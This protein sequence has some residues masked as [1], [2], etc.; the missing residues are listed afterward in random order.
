MGKGPLHDV[1]F[2]DADEKRTA[3][4]EGDYERANALIR[5]HPGLLD[6][7]RAVSVQITAAGR[8]AWRDANITYRRLVQ[9]YFAQHLT[10]TDLAALQ[11]VWGKLE[12]EMRTEP[13]DDD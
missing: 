1:L 6:D 5:T 2:W 3:I 13:N 10:D 8:Y 11:R 7:R 4:R 12:V 9:R